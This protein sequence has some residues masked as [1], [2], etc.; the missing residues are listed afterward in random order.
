MQSGQVI[1]QLLEAGFESGKIKGF[2]PHPSAFLGY[3][4]SH[5][6]YHRGEI[7]I[8]LTQTGTPL[9]DKI[10]YGMCSNRAMVMEC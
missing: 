7:G 6:S 3:L 2:K 1:E 5:E 10:L 4:I 9:D 8:I